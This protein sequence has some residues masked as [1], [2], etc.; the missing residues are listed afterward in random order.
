MGTLGARGGLAA[1]S[2]VMIIGC[3]AAGNSCC[4]AIIASG[5][6]CVFIVL[7]TLSGP[8]LTVPRAISF[9]HKRQKK[10]LANRSRHS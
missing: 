7:M 8:G 10:I 9:Q 4:A 1:S 2:P 5:S 6:S 3:P